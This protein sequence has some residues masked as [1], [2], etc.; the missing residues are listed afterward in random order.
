M[1][2]VEGWGGLKLEVET[3]KGSL[4]VDEAGFQVRVGTAG[5]SGLGPPRGARNGNPCA[6]ETVG[7]SSS[8]V[9]PAWAPA[10]RESSATRFAQLAGPVA[11]RRVRP[12]RRRVVG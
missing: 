12:P 4:V 3:K 5:G 6:R 9:A 11:R 7:R 2:V 10:R 8:A 1:L